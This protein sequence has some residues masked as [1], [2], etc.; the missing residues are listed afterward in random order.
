LA[1]RISNRAGRREWLGLA[2][3][4][5]LLGVAGATLSPSS[6]SSIRNVSFAVARDAKGTLGGAV[7]MAAGLP[8]PLGAE[9]RDAARAAFAP[10]FETA[11][12]ICAAVAMAGAIVA[13]VMLRDVP[14]RPEPEG[15][16]Q[17]QPEGAA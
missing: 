2:V 12:G 8:A 13:V 1:G 5:A 15:D 6:L 7:A 14:A 9:L 10:S 11:A 16:T 3:T 17:L 4:R